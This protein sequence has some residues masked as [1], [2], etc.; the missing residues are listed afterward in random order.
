VALYSNLNLF[1]I[2]LL[3]VLVPRSAHAP[4]ALCAG[5]LFYL[6]LT[7]KRRDLRKNLTVVAGS[8]GVERLVFSA[9]YKFSRVW[10]DNMLMM[11]LRGPRL[12]SL[13]G[14]PADE[15]P[16]DDALAAGRGAILVSV[17]LGNWELGGLGMAEKGYRMNI[18]TF[19]EPDAKVN[20]QRERLRRE[21]GI[22]FIYVDPN[23]KS[24]LAIIE[25]INAL[26]RNEVLAILGDRDGS[27]H[28]TALE[29]FGRQVQI[30]LGP[31]YL[32]LASG[33]P[34]IPVFVP[35][36]GERYAAIMEEPVFFRGERGDRERVIREGAQQ[37][38]R[39]F[40]RY[41]RAYPDQW[42]NFFDYFAADH[43]K[44]DK[45]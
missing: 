18:L 14:R 44:R 43:H 11:R 13:I 30:P 12:L 24:S 8:R 5:G 15:K 40:E 45:G 10:C 33:A 20:L 34:V 37:I 22:N 36:E 1:L 32:A 23:D 3:T 7:D 42:Y 6:I 28:T 19:R 21:R 17:H 16:L 26:N 38:V 29:F 4:F 35:L 39:V 31:A 2:R 9:F 27:S 25:A 41:I